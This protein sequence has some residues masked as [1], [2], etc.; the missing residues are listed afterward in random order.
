M[1]GALHVVLLA[2]GSGTRFWP[3]SR[4]RRPK[5]F[6]ALLG[7]RSLLEETWNRVRR[8]APAEK[9]WVVAP[10]ALAPSVRNALSELP[11][12]NLIL[13]PSPR[14]TAPAIGLACSRVRRR[15]PHAVTAFLPTDHVIRNESAFSKSVR[16]AAREAR[17]GALVCLGVRPVRPSTGFGYL[18]CRV[19]PTEGEPADVE[20]FV[21][22]P[23]LARARRFVRSGKYLWNAG[24]FVWKAGRFLE[25]L[26][27]HAPR[28]HDAVIRAAGGDRSA[29]ERAE[30]RSVDYAVMEK[31]DAVRVV[32]LDAGWDDVGSWDAVAALRKERLDEPRPA[33][34]LVDSK[35]SVVLAEGRCVAVV[36]VPGVVV[37]ETN[38][39][40]LVV[41]RGSS[42]Q[43]RRVVDRLR[44]RGQVDLL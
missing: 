36:G 35:D 5:Q 19:P 9:I 29:W 39:A 3:L 4:A 27:R 22:K 7:D 43:V 26:L 41:A 14:D 16:V 6:L 2:G 1:R 34:I 32:P 12:H 37:V 10:E 17:R 23:D 8:L 28:T 24:M 13:E 11:R 38:D 31:A 42:E 44:E 25:E 15:D 20:R 30:R 40:V 33:P 21:E 18:K